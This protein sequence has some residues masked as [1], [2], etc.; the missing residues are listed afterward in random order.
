MKRGWFGAGI[1]VVFLVLGFVVSFFINEAHLPTCQLL[2]QAAEKTLAGDFESAVPLGLEAKRRWEKQ[3]DA[4]AVVA[5]HSPMDDVDALFSEME[6]YAKAGEEPHF[7]AC[8]LE[9]AQ[10][11]QAVAEAHKFSWWN[12][13]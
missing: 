9:L 10:R 2:N 13:L 3:W 1:L 12:V 5:D 8:C 6:I 7:A 4:T 11:V